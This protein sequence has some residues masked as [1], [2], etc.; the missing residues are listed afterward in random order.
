MSDDE[1]WNA[2]KQTLSDVRMDRPV[3]AIE[4]R[5]RARQHRRRV[6]GIAA[7]GG[8]A[9]VTALALV[10]PMATGSGTA[11]GPTGP[12][13]QA[14]AAAP[15]PA[16]DTRLVSLA[17][18]L[19][20]DTTPL[21]GDASLIVEKVDVRRGT[22]PSRTRYHLYTDSGEYYYTEDRNELPRV[23][24]R[25]ENLGNGFHTRG[26]AAARYAATGDLATAREQMINSVYDNG[27]PPADAE[28]DRM[29]FLRR[30]GI[31]SPAPL[32]DEDRKKI[33]DNHLWV[34]SVDVLSAGGGDPQVR[35]G[36]LRLISTIPDVTV[37]D[38]TTG[39]RPTLTITARVWED[40]SEQI[41]IVDARSGVPITSALDYPDTGAYFAGTFKVS[42]VTV[43][44]IT[45]GRF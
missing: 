30:R 42:R 8:V 15:A 25:G 1:V 33:A 20:A 38:S 37:V 24:A 26:V 5:G 39:G 11:P 9:A 3:E 41:L 27:T 6:L 13:N 23:I 17:A 18:N 4:Q 40:D 16:G 36:V 12:D 7:G 43:A 21:P 28:Q 14:E 19:T 29:E 45:S 10:L 34:N 2:V 32:T 35:A 44:D 22:V 31:A